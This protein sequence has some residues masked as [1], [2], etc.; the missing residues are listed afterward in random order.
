MVPLTPKE[1]DHFLRGGL[2]SPKGDFIAYAVNYDYDRKKETETFRVVVQDLES[3]SK[4]VVARPDKPSSIGVYVDPKGKYILYNRSDED[5]SG[6]QWWIAS[7]DGNEDR[8]ILNFGPKAKVFAEW[9][10]DGRVAF[11]TDTIDGE[12]HDSVAVGLYNPLNG[13]TDWLAVPQEGEPFDDVSVPKYSHHVMMIQEREG[14]SKSFIYDLEHDIITNTAPLRGN[15]LPVSPI[16]QTEWLGI[17]YS[18]TSP[19]NLVKFNPFKPDFTKFEYLT[20]ML[21]GSGISEEELT[22][23]AAVLLHDLLFPPK[24]DS[25][26]R[27]FIQEA[28]NLFPEPEKSKELVEMTVAKIRLAKP[29]KTEFSEVPLNLNSIQCLFV[30]TCKFQL[31]HTFKNISVSKKY[32]SS[33]EEIG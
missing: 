13:K 23:N 12:R 20:N 4:T 2:F 31:K 9:T 22:G 33:S 3:G 16:S 15:L 8:E 26:R 1:P 32:L 7:Y 19:K 21:S 5:P 6:Y 10:H 30:E 27:Q 29:L 24:H 18:S 14:R 25:I 28:L 11:S 17:Y